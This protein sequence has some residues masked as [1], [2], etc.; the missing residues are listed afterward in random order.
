MLIYIKASTYRILNQTTDEGQEL[1]TQRNSG[2]THTVSNPI[3][4]GNNAKLN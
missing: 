1:I 3:I 2:H 4:Q